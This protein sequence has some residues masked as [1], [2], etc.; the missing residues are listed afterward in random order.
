MENEILTKEL[1]EKLDGSWGLFLR[2][3][4]EICKTVQIKYLLPSAIYKPKI[5]R[6]GNM[7]CALY[8]T[9]LQNGIAGFGKSPE[10]A[11]EAF[12][13]NWEDE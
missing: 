2:D 4:Y 8:G 7:W 9:D 10:K 5:Y 13:N 6:D 3:L 12:N 1:I 11:V